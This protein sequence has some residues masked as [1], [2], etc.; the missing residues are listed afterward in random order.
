M[1]YVRGKGFPALREREKRRL[2]R[3]PLWFWPAALFV[4]L[5]ILGLTRSWSQS[6][7]PSSSGSADTLTNWNELYNQGRTIY[8]RQKSDLEA[9]KTDIG[10]LKTGSER[11]TY[12]CGQLSRSNDDLN[13]YNE[14]IAERM[15]E[16]DEDLAAAYGT[17]DRLENK[18]LKLAIAVIILGLTIVLRVTIWIF[19]RR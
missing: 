10:N 1:E 5:L 4:L 16:R 13:R 8:G 18:I 11:L 14:Q 17:I 12:L 19:L 7:G 3:L 9:L 2:S 6:S 15:Q